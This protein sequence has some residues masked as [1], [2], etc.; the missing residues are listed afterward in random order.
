MS[1]ISSAASAPATTTA[2]N[3]FIQV[4]SNVFPN[5]FAQI[6]DLF[7][8][9]GIPDIDDFLITPADPKLFQIL[10]PLLSKRLGFLQRWHASQPN[11][12]Y[13]TWFFL[14]SS[15]AFKQWCVSHN[16]QRLNPPATPSIN[17]SSATVQAPSVPSFRTSMKVNIADYI[18]LKD[19]SQWRVFNRQL[20]ATAANHDTLEVL[21]PLF[22]PPTGQEDTFEQK[23]KFMY[24]MFSQCILTPNQ[25][26]STWFSL[27]SSN[28]FKQWCVSHNAQRLNPPAT[29]S[30]NAS[31]A[32]VQAPSVPSFR[33][34]MKVNIADYIKLK[35]DSQWRV[36]NRQLRATAANHD[37]LE[38]LDLV[39]PSGQEDTFEQ[40]CKFMYN[41]FSQ[42]ILTSK[43]KV[44]VRAQ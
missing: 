21:D 36:F 22:V 41:M 1:S 29:P 39:P 33:T 19:D 37:T 24:N 38:V 3:A 26:Y 35:D 27:I 14:I 43:G 5:A 10:A 30:I 40:K 2:Q 42:C 9:Y 34:S 15:N 28:A 6:D 25:D 16:D 4:F 18:K 8:Y 13:S 23:C 7:N 31:S 44:F 12:D 11:Q 17:A 32:T 20:R